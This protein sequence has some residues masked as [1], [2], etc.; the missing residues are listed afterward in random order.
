M[1]TIFENTWMYFKFFLFKFIIEVLILWP[2][3]FC[4]YWMAYIF[5]RSIDKN[6]TLWKWLLLWW[7][8]NSDEKGGGDPEIAHIDNWYGV[9]DMIDDE[10]DVDGNVIKDKY[11]IFA[12]MGWFRRFILSYAWGAFRNWTWNTKQALGLLLIGSYTTED[13]QKHMIVHK[14]EGSGFPWTWR[15]K[16]TLGIQKITFRLKGTKHFRYSFTLPLNRV[17]LGGLLRLFSK[18][19]NHF[20]I[21][22]G[23]DKKRYLFKARWFHV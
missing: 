3:G 14:K 5:R 6:P 7:V 18:K 9:Y 11:Q 10:V 17:W 8:S 4:T 1:K 15:N 13:I 16:T 21:M 23:T 12:E 20:N 2:I 19:R 22:I